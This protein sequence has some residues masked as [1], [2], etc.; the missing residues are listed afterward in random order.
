MNDNF[1]KTIMYRRKRYKDAKIQQNKAKKDRLKLQSDSLKTID[2][3][4][5]DLNHNTPGLSDNYNFSSPVV[6]TNF[7]G[8]KD[9]PTRIRSLEIKSKY[10]DLNRDELKQ[11]QNYYYM[12][13]KQE[14][15]DNRYIL[16]EGYRIGK[17]L[18]G[19]NARNT[20]TA[21]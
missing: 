5:N 20:V 1:F 10:Q 2:Y 21:S 8:D 6:V 3:Q 15:K 9:I 19:L 14:E 11:L 7:F 16:N 18:I 17:R 13:D 12:S 4:H